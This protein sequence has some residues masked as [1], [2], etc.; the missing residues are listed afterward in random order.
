MRDIGCVCVWGGV[1]GVRV[2]G[3]GRMDGRR[4]GCRDKGYRGE[5]YLD[6]GCRDKG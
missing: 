6:E 3:A 5:G 2:R 1:T 4:E